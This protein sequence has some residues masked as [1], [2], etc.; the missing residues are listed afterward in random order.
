ML[1]KHLQAYNK[2][3]GKGSVMG[4]ISNNHDRF[5]IKEVDVSISLQKKLKNSDLQ[6]AS[7]IFVSELYSLTYLLFKHGT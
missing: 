5:M 7:D 4:I 1:A 6:A 3:G 2:K